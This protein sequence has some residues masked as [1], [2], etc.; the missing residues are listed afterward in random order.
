M[1]GHGKA[2]V[3]AGVG[4]ASPTKICR[5]D[6]IADQRGHLGGGKLGHHGVAGAH[7]AT[8]VAY[9]GP[10]E[11]ELDATQTPCA[12]VDLPGETGVG[13]GRLGEQTSEEGLAG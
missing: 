6:R 5:R 3:V 12:L 1:L 7:T 13:D 4:L 9:G 10:G 11:A 2:E 8:P